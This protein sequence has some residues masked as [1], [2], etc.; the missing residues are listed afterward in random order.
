MENSPHSTAHS[1]NGLDMNSEPKAIE[2]VDGII[3]RGDRYLLRQ[4]IRNIVLQGD[5]NV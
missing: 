3:R 2:V 5:E 4:I 1:E